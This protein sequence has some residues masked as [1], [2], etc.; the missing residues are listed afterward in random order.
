MTLHRI[1]PLAPIQTFYKKVWKFI[2]VSLA[3]LIFSLG[4]GVAGYHFMGDL[5]FI[6]ALL[7]ASMILTGMGP[8]DTMK[9]DAA[10]LFS[11]FYAL[12]S[13]IAFLTTMA[14]LYAP[15]AQRFIHITHLDMID[16]TDENKPIV[17]DD[18]K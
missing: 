7:N 14:V 8:V 3:I 11:S 10:K 13:G 6:D 15:L 16:T 9:T 2:L 4:I 17:K 18:V 1:K 12:F 5:P